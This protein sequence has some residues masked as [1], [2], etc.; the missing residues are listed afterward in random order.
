[1]DGGM[2]GNWDDWVRSVK[3]SVFRQTRPG[4]FDSYSPPTKRES[5]LM[6][7]RSRSAKILGANIK[8]GRYRKVV[9]MGSTRKRSK[10]ARANRMFR[11]SSDA[12]FHPKDVAKKERRTWLYDRYSPEA[13]ETN[14]N[15][16]R[17]AGSLRERRKMIRGRWK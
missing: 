2:M 1:M 13:E 3:Q 7:S 14:E 6:K 11:Q 15:L 17:I 4:G 12:L 5:N 9:G 10:K 16:E 8:P